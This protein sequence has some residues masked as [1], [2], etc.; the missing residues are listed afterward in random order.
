MSDE[1]RVNFSDEERESEA[2]VFDTPPTG[3]YVCEI[4]KIEEKTVNET[5]ADGKPNKNAGKPYWSVTFKC[6]EGDYS[7]R[8]FWDNIALYEGSLYHLAQLMRATGNTKALETGK[9]PVPVS[10][11]GQRVKLSVRKVKDTYAMS[12]SSDDQI[13]WKNAVDGI[14]SVGASSRTSALP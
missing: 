11:I 6:V 7:N 1:L 5:G 12:K 3:K 2:R 4:E 9:V 10:L 14:E 8:R 13:I